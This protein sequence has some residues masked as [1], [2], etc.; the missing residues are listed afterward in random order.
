M[1]ERTISEIRWG[2]RVVGASPGGEWALMVVAAQ[3]RHIEGTTWGL[4]CY[5]RIDLLQ[6]TCE[7]QA[8]TCVR[9]SAP[10][11]PLIRCRTLNATQ[12]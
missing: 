8:S 3:L 10:K 9:G 1:S 7:E 11:K 2:T 5:L 4:L 12:S 6:S